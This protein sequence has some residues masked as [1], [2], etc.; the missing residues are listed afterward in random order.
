MR[1]SWD[2]QLRL[3]PTAPQLQWHTEADYFIL[4]DGGVLCPGDQRGSPQQQCEFAIIDNDP[5]HQ[6]PERLAPF[7]WAALVKFPCDPA[8]AIEQGHDLLGSHI[9]DGKP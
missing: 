4:R 7:C 6:L 8:G 5:R 2:D 3:D 9:P 1:L